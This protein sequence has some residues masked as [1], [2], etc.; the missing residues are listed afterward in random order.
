MSNT[1]AG[2]TIKA[3]EYEFD[4]SG[5]ATAGYTKVT[6][7]NDGKEPHVVE[8]LKLKPGKTVADALAVISVQGE[9]DPVAAAEVFDGDPNSSFYGTPGLIGPGDSTTTI[10]D[11]PAGNYAVVCYMPAPDGQPHFM[12]GMTAEL[13]V[14]DS[15][16]TSTPPQTDG[17][18]TISADGITAPDGMKSGTYEVTNTG[19][20]PSEFH[21]AGPTDK[22][23]TDIDNAFNSYFSTIGTGETPP[24]VLPA[25]IIGGFTDSIPAGKSGYV[26]LDL[27]T[28]HYLMAGNSDDN[29]NTLVSGS[30]DVS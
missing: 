16:G 8:A 7:E 13:A 20:D 15:G 30:F 1:D 21:V 19:S 14:A 3:T 25:P 29:G 4:I 18:I 6:F 9:P 11:F 28:G 10:A 2:L 27:D 26:V 17:T 23:I 12:L 24:F 22:T 5:T